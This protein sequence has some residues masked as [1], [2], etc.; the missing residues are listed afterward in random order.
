MK[1][2]TAELL[3]QKEATEAKLKEAQEYLNQDKSKLE[4]YGYTLD[5]DSETGNL[6]NYKEV[7]A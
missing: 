6:N 7:M 4:S 5:F 2:E 1:E 3:K